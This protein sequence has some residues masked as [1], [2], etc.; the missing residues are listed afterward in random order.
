MNKF[1]RVFFWKIYQNKTLGFTY[2]LIKY[3]IKFQITNANTV[4][5]LHENSQSSYD[6]KDYRKVSILRGRLD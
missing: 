1:I 6:A 5:Y 2:N 3:K 4:K